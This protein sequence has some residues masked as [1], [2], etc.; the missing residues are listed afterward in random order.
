MDWTGWSP[1]VSNVR[2][3]LIEDNGKHVDQCCKWYGLT[4]RPEG[5]GSILGVGVVDGYY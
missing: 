3:I 2:K 1:V 4:M 5:F